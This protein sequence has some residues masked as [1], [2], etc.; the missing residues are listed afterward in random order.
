MVDIVVAFVT[1]DF[2]WKQIDWEV[3]AQ[4]RKMMSIPT[5]VAGSLSGG[6]V[7]ND[8]PKSRVCG[9]WGRLWG[10]G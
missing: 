2:L 5:L 9:F 10:G 6:A 7:W 8:Q 3:A 4:D 1:V